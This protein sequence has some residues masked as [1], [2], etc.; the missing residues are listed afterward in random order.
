VAY[1]SAP[2]FLLAI[3][4]NTS[5]EQAGATFRLPVV[6]SALLT[7]ALTGDKVIGTDDGQFGVMLGPYGVAALVGRLVAG[8]GEPAPAGG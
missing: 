2:P 3:A 4:V 8:G 6:A 7:D 1:W 5:A